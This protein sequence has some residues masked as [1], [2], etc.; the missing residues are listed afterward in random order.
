MNKDLHDPPYPGSSERAIAAAKPPP[1]V[2]GPEISLD[3][4]PGSLSVPAQLHTRGQPCPDQ[5]EWAVE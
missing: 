3:G 5:G 1:P 2:T 4:Q